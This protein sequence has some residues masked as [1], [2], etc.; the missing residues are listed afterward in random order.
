MTE[1]MARS[2]IIFKRAPQDTSQSQR[3]S[4]P[5]QWTLAQPLPLPSPGHSTTS[6]PGTERSGHQS[7]PRPGDSA[8]SNSDL[9]SGILR[10]EERFQ[11]CA[12]VRVPSPF[13]PPLPPEDLLAPASWRVQPD[14][15]PEPQD[16][17]KHR[18]EQKE[19]H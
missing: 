9:D 11:T 8:S 19:G 2:K 4:E 12:G 18:Q 14:T 5:L 3:D 1:G 6:V 10:D 13:L 15:S 17:D 16:A 7:R